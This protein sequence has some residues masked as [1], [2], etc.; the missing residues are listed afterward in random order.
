LIIGGG[1]WRCARHQL[2]PFRP[3][4]GDWQV[5]GADLT[6]AEVAALLDAL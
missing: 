6:L 3:A 1:G 2:Q 5:L 4:D